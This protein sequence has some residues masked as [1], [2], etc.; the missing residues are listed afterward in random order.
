MIYSLN[1]ILVYKDNNTAV[2]ECGGVGYKCAVSQK[3]A[4]SLPPLKSETFLLTYMQVKEDAVDLFGFITAAELEIF[5]MIISVNGI[6]AKGALAILS[7]YTPDEV[8]LHIAAGD[9]K[10]ISAAQGVGPKI[11]GRIVLELK[12]KLGNGSVALSGDA[13]AALST[14]GAGSA[15]KDAVEALTTFGFTASEASVAVGKCDPGLSVDELIKQA[16]KYLSKKV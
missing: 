15:L 14:S 1:G 10:A 7:I 12:D 8:I 13:K 2:I 9:S 3:T 6:G 5:K 4:A 11:A 16:L